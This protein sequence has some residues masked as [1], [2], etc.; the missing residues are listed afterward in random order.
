MRKYSAAEV[1]LQGKEGEEQKRSSQIMGVKTNLD[2]YFGFRFS[3]THSPRL[4]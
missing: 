4:C 2:K 1:V 3:G